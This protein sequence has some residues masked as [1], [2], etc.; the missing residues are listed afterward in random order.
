[1]AYETLKEE[2]LNRVMKNAQVKKGKG[3]DKAVHFVC[4]GSAGNRTLGSIDYLNENGYIFRI[5][6]EERF[7]NI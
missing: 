2:H 7:K 6:N 5:I 1:M 4:R 3:I